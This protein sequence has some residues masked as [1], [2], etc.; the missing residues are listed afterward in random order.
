V[1][2]CMLGVRCRVE[3]EGREV[4]KLYEEGAAVTQYLTAT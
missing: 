2:F 1:G 4:T 3:K